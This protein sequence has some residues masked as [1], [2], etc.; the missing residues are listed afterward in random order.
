VSVLC[1]M[2]VGYPA[3]D[4]PPRPRVPLEEIRI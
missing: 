4:P 2:T 3:K 1:L